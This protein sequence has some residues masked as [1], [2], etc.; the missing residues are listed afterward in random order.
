[1]KLTF[2]I[3]VYQ[4]LIFSSIAQQVPCP[5]TGVTTNP[6][7]PSNTIAPQS[8]HQMHENDFFDWR[9]LIYD[10]QLGSSLPPTSIINP[11]YDPN[12]A[13]NHLSLNPD[14]LPEDG[15]ELLYVDLGLDRDGNWNPQSSAG[16]LYLILYNKY[17][18]IIRVFVA[19]VAAGQNSMVEMQLKM[20]GG[21]NT[22]LFASIDK[23]QQPLRYFDPTNIASNTQLFSNNAT[24]SPNW[25]Y[26]DF[27]V[28]YDPCT[29][30]DYENTVPSMFEFKVELQSVGSIELIG[31]SSG[32]LKMIEKT[33]GGSTQSSW[34]KF[35]GTTKK[36]QGSIAAGRKGFKDFDAFKA[37]LKNTADNS[38]SSNKADMKAAIDN[39]TGFL[40]DEI[41]ALGVVPY[42][43]EALALIDFFTGGGKKS[44]PQEVIFPPMSIQLEHRFTGSLR[45]AS[46]YID[47]SIY[48]PGSSFTPQN[49][50][51]LGQPL[52]N[53]DP[54]Y[55]IYNEILGVYTLLDKPKVDMYTGLTYLE[56]EEDYQQGDP[57]QFRVVESRSRKWFKI[58]QQSIKI[59]V[60]PA[61][62]LTLEETY[63]QLNVTD[64]IRD[65]ITTTSGGIIVNDSLWTSNLLPLPC[66]DNNAVIIDEKKLSE[67]SDLDINGLSLSLVLVFRNANGDKFLHKSTWA[68]EFNQ[69]YPYGT[70]PG[71]VGHPKTWWNWFDHPQFAQQDIGFLNADEDLLVSNSTVDQDISAFQTI[72]IENSTI[73]SNSSSTR[74]RVL[75]GNSIEVLPGSEILPNTVLEVSSVGSNCDAP[76]AIA[77]MSDIESVCIGN[78]YKSR[79]QY[80]AKRKLEP[81]IHDPADT[82]MRFWLFPNPTNGHTTIRWSSAEINDQSVWV[83]VV[84]ISGTEV[85]S[86]KVAVT[87]E[88]MQF[89]LSDL[90]NG[91]YMVQLKTESGYTGIRKLVKQ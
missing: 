55:P 19:I 28:N 79:N 54:R 49:T 71:F 11:N 9:E 20:Y 47:R 24:N 62:Q 13:T 32:T 57:P 26:A 84:D 22:A 87:D 36:V 8:L 65:L 60:N 5:P 27:P 75:A 52:P 77:S 21:N 7:A 90:S 81:E 85:V 76:I 80:V 25:F 53:G 91:V 88:R 73:K 33:A 69:I 64:T 82:Q 58:D 56:Q 39:L 12:G 3:F 6:D 1:M 86:R 72:T 37:D 42:V 43:S 83:S 46:N 23:V 14:Y 51:A 44:G 40:T 18:G 15:W 38:G 67:P 10:V 16:D 70:S 34:D 74:T 31:E 4:L 59:A 45:L 30:E 78:E 89:D 29:C 66:I 17:R 35:Y 48:T 61:S 50:N 63:C 41:P 2:T 68:V